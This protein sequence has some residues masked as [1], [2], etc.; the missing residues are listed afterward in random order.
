MSLVDTHKCAKITG[1]K[2]Q[3]LRKGRTKNAG[4]L[5]TPPFIKEDGHIKYDMD[6]LNRWIKFVYIPGKRINR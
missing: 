5:Q 3:T 4:N 2:E 6:C 1:I